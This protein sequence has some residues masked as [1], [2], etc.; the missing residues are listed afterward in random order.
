MDLL[1]ISEINPDLPARES[2]QFKAT[3]TLIWPYSSSARQFALLLAEPDFRLRRKKGQ[4]RV[5]F[6]GSSAK[7]IATTG[8]GI[9]DEVILSLRGVQF[10]QEGAVNTPGKSIDW[11]LSYSQTVVIQVF[12]SGLET[13]N[14]EL[15]DVAPTPAPRSPIRREQ[16]AVTSPAQQ[17]YSP[18]FLKRVRL[19]DGPFLDAPYDPLADENEEEHDKKRRRKSYRDW[20]AWTYSARTPSPEKEDANMEEDN[21]LLEL[22]PSRPAQLPR[23]PVSPTNLE[24][25]PAAVT[26]SHRIA[27]SE[28]EDQIQRV[29][30]SVTATGQ[31]GKVLAA[32]DDLTPRREQANIERD[33]EYDELY[34]GPNE[35]PSSDAQYA[36]GGDTE[37]DTEVDTEEESIAQDKLDTASV[38]V[39]DVNN[40]EQGDY[41]LPRI[42]QIELEA[43]LVE[44]ALEDVVAAKENAIDE[45][46]LTEVVEVRQ[47]TETPTA[48]VGDNRR[49]SSPALLE[50]LAGISRVPTIVMPPPTL[51]TIQTDFPAI[52][53]SGML[54]PIGQEPASPTLRPLDSAT[55]PLP[56][57]FPGERDFNITSYLDHVAADQDV[58]ISESRAADEQEPPSD[59]SYIFETSFFSSINS[60]KASAFHPNHESAF[61]PVRFTFGMDGAGFSRPMELSSPDPEKAALKSTEEDVRRDTEGL[62]DPQTDTTVA[63][64]MQS[65]ESL[66]D[67]TKADRVGDFYFDEGAGLHLD[68]IVEATKQPDV[69][70][71]SSGSES[72]VIE[73]RTSILGSIDSG[74]HS[75]RLV[76][77]SNEHDAKPR[78]GNN[79]E[80]AGYEEPLVYPDFLGSDENFPINNNQFTVASEQ[81]QPGPPSEDNIFDE[82]RELDMEPALKQISSPSM[83]IETHTELI[84]DMDFA[85]EALSAVEV[86][87]EGPFILSSPRQ[88]TGISCPRDEQLLTVVN[89]EPEKILDGVD[90]EVQSTFSIEEPTHLQGWQ[91]LDADDHHPDI[92]IESV[93][94]AAFFHE[95]QADTQIMQESS[96]ELLIM[97]P[98][99]GHK[100]GELHTISVPAKG[101]ARN[102][103]SKTK[104][105][106]SPTKD[107]ALLPKRTTRSTRSKASVTPVTHTTLSPQR[108]R[109]HSTMSPPQDVTQTSPYSLRSQSKLLSPTKSIA[110]TALPTPR[111]HASKRSLDSVSDISISH[112]EELEPSRINFEPSQELGTLQGQYTSL[113]SDF[114]QSKP[115][116]VDETE[117]TR[118]G[119]TAAVEA[120]DGYASPKHSS[121]VKLTETS[122]GRHLRS[123]EA[124]AEAVPSSPHNVRRTRRHVYNLSQ[125]S[126]NTV[127][128]LLEAAKHGAQQDAPVPAYPVLPSEGEGSH[129]AS[130]PAPDTSAV[131]PHQQSAMDSNRLLTPEATQETTMESQAAPVATQPQHTLLITPQPT[132]TASAELDSSQTDAHV[133]SMAVKDAIS[134]PVAKSTPRRNVTSTDVASTS[135]SPSLKDPSSDVE[136]DLA[137]EQPSIGLSTP[138]AYY[139][140]IKDLVYFLNRSSQ[141]HSS[142][143]PD[144]LALVTSSTTP[145]QRATKGPKHWNTTLHITDLSTWPVTTTVNVFRAYQTALPHAD[146]G[147]IILL[148]SFAVK[149][150]NRHPTLISGDESSWCVWRY[151]KPTWGTQEGPFGDIKAREEIRGPAVES[152]E[153]EWKEV[154]RLR[155]W[156]EDKIKR[157]LD[158]KEESQ[159][160]TR[161]KDKAAEEMGESREVDGAEQEKNAG[162]KTRSKAKAKVVGSEA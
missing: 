57:P 50:D 127:G 20:T 137:P 68:S 104:S 122:P 46:R 111:K 133:D 21:S 73:D 89:T 17:W 28:K 146:A 23:T 95:S 29:D 103:R 36:F 126:N 150:L 60:S 66:L 134:S 99:E 94:E 43:E 8:V 48:L 44:N 86:A 56:S 124:S 154:G 35:F 123:A 147:D 4:V 161:S 148:R 2:K 93:E 158:M 143:N 16:V 142:E 53:T 61:T 155:H 59:A 109:T 80:F 140:P 47:A 9:G 112:L 5:R 159:V 141:F 113:N 39:S 52:A 11:E 83:D 136:S 156:Y 70:E 152:G 1:R 13:A 85:P 67:R 102:T 115:P 6:S 90:T 62:T 114:S 27:V 72:E 135:A 10:V 98:G 157:E 71:L 131:P 97:V 75:D 81:V 144:V 91:S 74:V 33:A 116:P 110:N 22:S 31:T 42:K 26:L 139:T 121:T 120:K 65:S 119:A 37:V 151:G 30:A 160:K 55:L 125:E 153:G 69:I 38:S 40:Q 130:P 100:L 15:V 49:S 88:E 12:R 108:T 105:S 106:A 128:E 138:L 145:S 77:T 79:Y 101:P 64:D 82:K 96:S 162:V 54:T 76:A 118:A 84:E 41:Q 45:E 18:A 63:M 7:A 25:L 117:T 107:E 58:V 132:Q 19:S 149:S 3:V 14:L 129:I 87:E 34:A 92:K 78:P 24:S 32:H 51:A